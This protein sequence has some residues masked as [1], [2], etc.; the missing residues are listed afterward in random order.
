M[1]TKNSYEFF[2]DDLYGIGPFRA[3][4]EAAFFGNNVETLT[5]AR[6]Y[7]LARRQPAIRELDVPM[8]KPEQ[9]GIPAGSPCLLSIDG[10]V[11]GR[12][13][14]ARRVMRRVSEDDRKKYLGILREAIFD[15]GSKECLASEAIGGLSEEFMLRMRLLIPKRHAK[16][17]SDWLTN[18]QSFEGE[19]VKRYKGSVPIKEPDILVLMDPEWRHPDYPD[20]LVI[21]D[22][23]K[24]AI[25][26]LGLRYFGELKK[27][28]LTLIWRAAVR[29]NMVPCHGGIRED[30]YNGK[31][32]ITAN[33]GLSGSGK[34]ALTN[35][36]GGVI[37]H[38]DAFVIDLDSNRSIALEPNLFDKTDRGWTEEMTFSFMNVGVVEINGKKFPLLNDV[39]NANGRCI[40]SRDVLGTVADKTGKPDAVVWLMKDSTLPPIVRLDNEMLAVAM[41]ATLMTKRTAAENVPAEEMRKL[42]FEPFANPFRCHYLS[43]DCELFLKLFKSGTA[44]YVFNTGGYWRNSDTDLVDVPKDL[45]L[46]LQQAIVADEIEFEPWKILP[47]ASVPKPG[48]M[49][50][51]WPDYDKLFDPNRTI[52]QEECRGEM[53]DRFGQRISFLEGEMVKNLELRQNLVISLMLP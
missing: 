12:T 34:S 16:N 39:R 13:A 17:A 52:K 51:I 26:I 45:S 47:G 41:G 4:I 3:T 15:M 14:R 21:V 24:N 44:C 30:T 6:I 5:H 9:F 22:D 23:D 11:V 35:R 37:I 50:N 53:F 40:K 7:E 2:K 49:D 27:G 18:F 1:T 31:R 10:D 20:G 28:T 19:A 25:A 8:Y 42:V 36:K 46:R 38:D 48:A 33:F 29:Q 32:R 43:T